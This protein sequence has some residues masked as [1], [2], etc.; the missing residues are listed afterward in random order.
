MVQ[1][2]FQGM[3]TAIVTPFMPDKSVDFETFE[4]LVELQII[5]KADFIVVLGTTGES[6]TL[7][8][9][10][11]DRLIQKTIE[12]VSGRIPVV[13]GIG[14]SDTSEIVNKLKNFNHK[15]ID[16][17]LSVTPC[18]NKPSQAGLYEHYKAVS[19][20][21]QLPV[22]LYNVPGRTAV[23]LKAETTLKLASDF[24]NIVAIKEA[25]GDI[26]QITTILQHRNEDFTVLSGDDALTLP[27]MPLGIDGVI[28]V[29]GNAFPK[30]WTEMVHLAMKNEYKAASK[31]HM[32]FIDLIKLLFVEGNP[33]GI[34]A[35]MHSKGLLNNILRLPLT[36]VSI[37][38]YNA[39]KKSLIL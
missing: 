2:K 5:S 16:G 26:A 19:E 28:S 36:P 18:Y 27:L 9:Q 7:N 22:I 35:V 21:S 6:V 38:T 4:K 20:N 24:K 17:I 30:E 10:E 8:H 14:C 25:S 13:V 39:I 31:I 32:Q 29:L 3:G 1:K 23:N 12:K 15:G 33:A 37:E 11:K 34:K